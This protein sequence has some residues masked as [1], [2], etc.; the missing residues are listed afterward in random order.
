VRSTITTG[1]SLTLY[2]ALPEEHL[3]HAKDSHAF[4]YTNWWRDR[5]IQILN[6]RFF[7]FEPQAYD[8]INLNDYE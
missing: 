4:L 2:L 1:K 8:T 6:K 5:D 7:S 3:A